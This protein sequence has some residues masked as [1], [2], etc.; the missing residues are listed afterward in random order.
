VL[1]LA[2]ASP[3]RAETLRRLGLAFHH[4]APQVEEAVEPGLAPAEVA[5][6]L[7]RAKAEAVAADVAEGWVLGADTI[8]WCEGEPLGKPASAKEALATL[9][10]LNGRAHDVYTGVCVARRP[11]GKL[12]E[13]VERTTVRFARVPEPTLEAYVETGEPLGKAGAYAVQGIAAAFIEEVRGSVDNVVGL[14]I[15]P[16]VQLLARAGFPLPAHLGQ[17]AQP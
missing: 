3:R 7:A 1:V 17:G 11:D 5:R 14:P 15:R 4:V 16:T 10:K 8:V 2:S 12:F 9:L 6:L 13:H